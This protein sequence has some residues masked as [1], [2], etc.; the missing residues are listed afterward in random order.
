MSKAELCCIFAI[1]A[2]VITSGLAKCVEYEASKSYDAI[3]A[4]KDYGPQTLPQIE[5]RTKEHPYTVRHCVSPNGMDSFVFDLSDPRTKL[6]NGYFIADNAVSFI[7]LITG[8]YRYV[9]SSSHVAK[10]NCKIGIHR[11]GARP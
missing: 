7:D 11:I 3:H 2:I 8:K 6:H 4:M 5:E 10:Y 1:P 9:T